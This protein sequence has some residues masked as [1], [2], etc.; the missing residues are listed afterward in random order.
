VALAIPTSPRFKSGVTGDGGRLFEPLAVKS[1]LLSTE[2]SRLAVTVAAVLLACAGFTAVLIGAGEPSAIDLLIFLLICFG[3]IWIAT[4][5]HR[6]RPF[7]QCVR[8]TGGI[9]P[10]CAAQLGPAA[11]GRCSLVALRSWTIASCSALALA[12]P[13]ICGERADAQAS[14]DARE[15]TINW[16]GNVDDTTE[17]DGRCRDNAG[18]CSLRAAIQEANQT[19]VRDTI[20]FDIPSS[21]NGR[22]IRVST[23]PRELPPI[24]EPVF[25]DGWSQ[26]GF[27]GMPLVTLDG[28]TAGELRWGLLVTG[29]PSAI[30]GLVISNF[31]GF[32]EADRGQAGIV[33]A[34]SGGHTVVGN[35]VGTDASGTS[36]QPN[37]NGIV[38]ASDDNLI[39]GPAHAS[40][41]NIVSHNR[42]RGID[43]SGPAT[44]LRGT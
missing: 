41:R 20:K 3:S 17:G 4:Q 31:G 30:R 1:V 37:S 36:A 18:N 12:A 9:T 29:G 35:F 28:G 25:I 7:G 26:P 39:G 5:I 40:L 2:R 22:K 6:A 27:A 10:A 11:G 23:G 44:R 38:V 32:D 16:T 42:F 19:P 14:A 34:G 13:A 15:F 33:L 8:E 24:T 21:D 43:V